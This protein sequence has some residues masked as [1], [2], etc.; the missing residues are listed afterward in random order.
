MVPL[1]QQSVNGTQQSLSGSLAQQSFNKTR[2]STD[3]NTPT[4]ITDDTSS[5][6]IHTLGQDKNN[7]DNSSEVS[8][9]QS[10]DIN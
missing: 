4:D 5:T 9:S 1:V 7:V 10:I 2:H 3:L 8:K 6:L